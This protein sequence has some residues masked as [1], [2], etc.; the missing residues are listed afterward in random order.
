MELHDLLLPFPHSGGRNGKRLSIPLK[1]HSRRGFVLI[2]MAC[3]LVVMLAFV[4]LALD[5]GYLQL[6]QTRMQTAADAAAL[7]GVQEFRMNGTA[8]IVTAARA[9]ATLNGLTD[10][11]TGVTVTVNNPPTK[12][13]SS[14]N[15]TAVEVIIT[16]QVST[17]F[18]KMVG[19]KTV[20]LTAR[21]VAR[22]GSGTTCVHALDNTIAAAFSVSNGATLVAACGISTDSSS[23]TAINDAGGAAITTSSVASYG[24]ISVSGGSHLTATSAIANGTVSVTGGSIMTPAA[25]IG[26]VSRLGDPLGYITAPTVG[27]CNYNNYV[28]GGGQTLTVNPGVYCGG[29]Q[30]GNGARVTFNAGT[31]IIKGG[32]LNINGGVTATGTGITFYN[33]GAAGYTYSPIVI[34]NGAVVTF[35][36]PTTGGYAGILFFQDRSIVSAAMNQ[37]VGGTTMNLTGSMYFPTTP[38]TFSNGNSTASPYSIIVAKNVVFSGGVKVNNDYSS[39]PG[40]SPVRG[41]AVISE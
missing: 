18:M 27:S 16:K 13:Y 11:V 38:V 40:G 2:I 6:I 35:S 3:S 30:L 32:G 37:F 14:T 31:Y 33:T 12:G 22:Q 20:T 9:D 21:S 5:T 39:L 23:A 34:G 41:N 15:S 19:S 17:Y 26:G 28:A 1:N 7:G 36:A 25:T 10:G 29:M 24:G 8:N 4:G